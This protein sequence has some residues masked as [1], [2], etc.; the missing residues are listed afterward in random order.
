MT[1]RGRF[2]A[3][4]TLM[5]SLT[6]IGSSVAIANVP[7]EEHPGGPGHLE[8]SS[9][10]VNVLS[11][12]QLTNVDGGIADVGYFDGYAY[13]NAFS[14]ECAGR[15][16]AQGTGVHIVDVRDLKNP[17]KVGFIPAHVNSYVGEGIHVVRA[18]TTSFTGD[19]LIHNNETCNSTLF[20]PSGA[21]LWDVTNPL[22]PQPL[23]LNFGDPSPA[24]ANQSFHTVHS[25]QMF[26]QY[27]AGA[28]GTDKV[29]AVLQD[30]QDLN[31]VDILDI[32]DPRNPVMLTELGSRAGHR[33]RRRWP[34]AT[35]SSITTSS[36][37][38]STVT[39]TW[40]F[41]T[42]TPGRSC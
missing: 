11:K 14:P 1:K 10:N 39:T 24:V 35:P 29:F 38:E 2:A 28:G 7:G 27:G 13:L 30:N 5:S 25:A 8:P 41:P 19:I 26:V 21:S 32:T 42:G 20:T 40:L 15:P 17:A 34:M 18:S 23:S 3:S 31:D 33:H 12:L 22:S 36:T 37:S 6:L 16:G 4:V 9:H